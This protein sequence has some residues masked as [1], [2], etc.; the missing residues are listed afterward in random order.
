M[1]SRPCV[2]AARLLKEREGQ[3]NG[4]VLLLFQPAEEGKGGGKL[5]ADSGILDGVRALH[6]LHVWPDLPSGVIASKASICFALQK[7][8]SVSVQTS[9]WL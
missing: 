7:Y 9:S 5:V 4:A 6:G 8:F 2:V 3:L 1:L